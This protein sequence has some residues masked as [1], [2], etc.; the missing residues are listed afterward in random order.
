MKLRW[1]VAALLTA[2]AAFASGCDGE[3]D[4]D[5]DGPEAPQAARVPDLAHGRLGAIQRE[6]R[7]FDTSVVPA[8]DLPVVQP[9]LRRQTRRVGE[10]ISARAGLEV[11]MSGRGTG[12]LYRYESARLAEV[13]AGGFLAE[14]NSGFNGVHVCGAN[15]Y[16]V[17]GMKP[18]RAGENW[19]SAA[20]SAVRRADPA[21]RQTAMLIE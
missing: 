15:V 16:F 4:V 5:R 12:L 10:R 2:A 21:C 3:S 19:P 9:L 8:G 17:R 1:L 6:L 14:G 7:R 11:D 20:E 13:A 18:G